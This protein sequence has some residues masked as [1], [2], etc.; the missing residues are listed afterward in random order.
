[1]IEFLPKVGKHA[2]LPPILLSTFSL[3]SFNLM[4]INFLFH[5]LHCMTFLQVHSFHNFDKF[6]ILTATNVMEFVLRTHTD[7]YVSSHMW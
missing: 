3:C 1:M 7:S 5:F 6:E 2:L 4:L